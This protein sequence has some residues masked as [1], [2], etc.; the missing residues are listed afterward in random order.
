MKNY[1]QKNLVKFI[2]YTGISTKSLEYKPKNMGE[3]ELLWRNWGEKEEEEEV[4]L[5]AGKGKEKSSK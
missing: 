2:S 3:K 1:S 5:L 4:V